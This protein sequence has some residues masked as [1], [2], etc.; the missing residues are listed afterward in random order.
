MSAVASQIEKSEALAESK[1]GVK[2]TI[3]EKGPLIERMQPMYD[4]ALANP[5]KA[6]LLET[7]FTVQGR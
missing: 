2:Y 3:V 4:D 5:V 6:K 7:I 1:L